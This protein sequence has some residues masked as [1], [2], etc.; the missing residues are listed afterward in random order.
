M[1]LPTVP[2]DSGSRSMDRRR[3][4]RAGARTSVHRPNAE[5]AELG[6]GLLDVSPDGAGVRLTAPVG[7]GEEL[8]VGLVRPDGRI[9][10]RLRAVVR[11]CRPIGGGL[12]A[13]GFRFDRALTLTE[14]ADL[15]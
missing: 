2:R 15:V 6:A 4:V 7:M 5:V 12:Y 9:V 14:L 1:T 10:A 11:W 13:V 8:E 3:P